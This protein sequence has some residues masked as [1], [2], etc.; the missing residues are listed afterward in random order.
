VAFSDS[1]QVWGKAIGRRRIGRSPATFLPPSFVKELRRGKRRG[2][3]SFLNRREHNF[4][5]TVPNTDSA[6]T[7]F[8]PAEFVTQIADYSY[9]N[10]MN[11]KPSAVKK[12]EGLGQGH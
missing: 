6:L 5:G 7:F 8:H 1:T 4:S 2:K 11:D 3:Q 12:L 10:N 9:A